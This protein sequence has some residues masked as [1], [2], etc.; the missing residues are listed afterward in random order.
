[1]K[2]TITCS[3]SSMQELIKV[4]QQITE[5]DEYE[6]T[7]DDVSLLSDLL[8]ALCRYVYGDFNAE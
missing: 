6:L 4:L 8:A 3:M 2:V 7:F 1:M 5:D